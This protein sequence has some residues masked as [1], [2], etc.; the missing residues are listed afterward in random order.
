[1][2]VGDVVD[3]QVGLPAREAAVLAAVEQREDLAEAR[4]AA[5]HVGGG[6]HEREAVARDEA[7]GAAE[8]LGQQGCHGL[9]ALDHLLQRV[10]RVLGLLE[11]VGDAHAHVERAHGGAHEGLAVEHGAEQVAAGG[12]RAGARLAQGCREQRLSLLVEPRILRVRHAGQ[13]DGHH[14]PPPRPAPHAHD[15]LIRGPAR[16]RP[17]PA[18]KPRPHART[19]V[20]RKPPPL[21]EMNRDLRSPYRQPTAAIYRRG[22]P[23]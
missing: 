20:G 15:L 19:P 18:R 21:R 4:V 5:V 14:T 9:Q 11:L 6:Q 12:W 22:S 7:I 23:P 2:L 8:A 16:A 3:G 17:A 13:G 1:V 10:L